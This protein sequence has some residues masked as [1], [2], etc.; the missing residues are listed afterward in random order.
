MNT[1]TGSPARPTIIVEKL[2]VKLD[3]QQL[4]RT[5]VAA[6][7]FDSPSTVNCQL[8]TVNCQLSTVN[9]QLSTVN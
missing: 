9:C 8:S 3:A 5:C 2:T 1:E 4:S 7:I 6:P